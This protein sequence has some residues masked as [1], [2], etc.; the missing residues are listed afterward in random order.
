MRI[1]EVITEDHIDDMLEDAAA[2]PAIVDPQ[3]AG[4]TTGSAAVGHPIVLQFNALPPS[5]LFGS[6]DSSQPP[7][8]GF[9]DCHGVTKS[10][11][12]RSIRAK[13][14]GRPA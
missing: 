12:S 14:A 7:D 10:T 6:T 3:P 4:S 9:G 13:C 1:R 2:D 5:T 8:L 11:T